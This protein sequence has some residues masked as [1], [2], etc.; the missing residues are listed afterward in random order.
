[1]TPF[2]RPAT[3]HPCPALG[4]AI[5]PVGDKSLTHRALIL[6]ALARGQSRIAH[7]NPGEDCR[8]TARSLEQIGA[9]LRPTATGWEI[10]GAAGGL[11]D[12]DE[13]LHMGNS[14]TGLRLMAGVIAGQSLYGVLT[15][16][17]SLRERPMRRIAEPLERM[18]A[19]VLLRRGEFPPIA[20]RGGGMRPIE[21]GLP[22]ASAQVKG[23]ILIAALG[24]KEGRVILKEPGPSRDHTERMLAWLGVPISRGEDTVA[25]SAP[26]QPHHGFSWIIPADL[27]AAC[28]Y[29]VAATLVPGSDIRLDGVLLNPTRSGCL[30]ILREMGADLTIDETGSEG[31]EPVGSIRARSS[32]LRGVTIS[33]S[34]LLRAADEV[35]I[36]AVAAVAATG[37]TVIRD[38][39][40]L[41]VKE[42]DRI[43]A[44][45]DLVRSLG[46]EADVGADSIRIRGRGFLT[47]G[48]V[49]CRGDHRLAMSA[50]VAGCAARGPVSV[51]DVGPVATSDPTFLDRLTQLGGQ[52][53]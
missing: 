29:I 52:L 22:V 33:G 39:A 19:T 10:T 4:G 13:I 32:A 14:G 16:D 31:P 35:P 28:F 2:L 36:L 24:L 41:R 51:D 9:R 37:E 1:M 7:P 23:C 38:A 27:S 26:L 3:A 47:G 46:G 30:D 48:T 5:R 17:A 50:L 15:G 25:L 8:A 20:V 6:A 42:S 18:G 45:A 12:P 40:E 49:A 11:H 43:E 53:T 34:L 44:A 21:Y